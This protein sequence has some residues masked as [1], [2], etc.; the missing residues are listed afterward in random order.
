MGDSPLLTLTDAGGRNDYRPRAWKQQLQE[1]LSDR[2]GLAVTICHCK[3]G[4]SKWDPIKHRWFS[5][6]SINWAGKPLRSFDT[7]LA[8]LR[9]NTTAT[10][11][12]VT[13]SLLEGVYEKGLRVS[14]T[15]MKQLSR[16]RQA[17]CPNWDYT[18]R[19]H[20]KVALGTHAQQP[21]REVVL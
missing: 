14:D 18:I 16:E 20:S 15:E 11:L 5:Q 8:C 6:I 1:R 12:T 17:V 7:M 2:H 3:A 9:G 4:C 19:P 21:N 10:C 13:A